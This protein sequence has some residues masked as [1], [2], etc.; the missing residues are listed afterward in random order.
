MHKDKIFAK[1]TPTINP[2]EFNDEVAKVFTDMLHRS[3]PGYPLTIQTIKSLTKK[4][5]Q[6]N[7]NCYDL[8]CSLGEAAFAIEE[9][10]TVEGCKIIAID[11]SSS[12][13]K[14]CQKK[15]NNKT[16]STPITIVNDDII[17]LNISNASI[18]VM[19]Y[20][21]QFIDI[22]LRQTI[23]NKI[24]NGLKP[25]GLFIL[26]EKTSNDNKMIDNLL[27]ELH[28]E[29]KFRNSYSHLEISQK[30]IALEKVLICDDIPTHNE[31]LKSAGFTN[32]DL[33]LQ[34]FNFISYVAIK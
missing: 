11:K 16:V 26:S 20:T 17:N 14:K 15:L 13:T 22:D 8:G 32:Y 3:I 27:I 34:H 30:R 31:R 5:I 25:G 9:G 23:L 7:S 19:N 6:P 33:W 4:F 10:I 2:F 29:H 18:V 28:H 24:Y 21:L 1:K 12:M